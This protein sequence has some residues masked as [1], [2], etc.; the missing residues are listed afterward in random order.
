MIARQR[1]AVCQ[2]ET[3]ALVLGLNQPAA[4]PRQLDWGATSREASWG[5]TKPSWRSCS[6]D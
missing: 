2:N 6:F 3:C 5:Y 1:D 4:Q